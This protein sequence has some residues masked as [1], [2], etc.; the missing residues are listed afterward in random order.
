MRFYLIFTRPQWTS[1]LTRGAFIIAAYGALIL[2][3]LLC[4]L[5]GAHG[6]QQNLISYLVIPAALMT[7]V[8]TAF[9]FAQS[10]ARDL[11]QSPLLPFHMGLQAILAGAAVM[12]LFGLGMPEFR[13][14]ALWTLGIAALIHVLVIW[15]EVALPSVTAHAKRA[16]QHLVHGVFKKFFWVGVLGGGVAPALLLL[17]LP[18]AFGLFLAALLALVGLL[19][20][21]HAYVQA[22]QAVPLA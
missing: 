13:V 17:V 19:A 21:E 14:A 3:W 9:L 2:A 20:Y 7:A 5:T 1:W 22:G 8:Y 15:G 18:N 10:K 6:I 11:W 4:S 16:E 12:G